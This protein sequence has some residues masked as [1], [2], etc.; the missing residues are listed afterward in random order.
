MVAAL[1]R[2]LQ[3]GFGA[4]GMGNG[5]A[6]GP[7]EI[8][9]IPTLARAFPDGENDGLGTAVSFFLQ[10]ILRF[11]PMRPILPSFRYPTICWPRRWWNEPR[12][13]LF[14]QWLLF[15]VRN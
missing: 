14:D 2:P 4:D 11:S 15:A 1:F 6:P 3:P 13:F 10:I 9:A 12:K 7:D 5:R 8:D